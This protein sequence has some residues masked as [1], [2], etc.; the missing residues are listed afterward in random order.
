MKGDGAHPD[1]SQGPADLQSAALTTELCTHACWAR[2]VKTFQGQTFTESLLEE[3]APR[4]LWPAAVPV[5]GA[6]LRSKGRRLGMCS[7]G[8]T[9][10]G[11]RAH[12]D[13]S[14]GP[15]DLQSAVLTTELCTH[16]HNMHVRCCRSEACVAGAKAQMPRPWWR[17]CVAMACGA[18]APVAHVLPA[19][20][21]ACC[22]RQ[23]HTR[24]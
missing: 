11:N 3:P 4:L 22:D 5:C 1:L 7:S 12:P 9:M 23:G 17:H 10:K 13:L 20:Q 6:R 21:Q 14:Q 24:I 19:T 2:Q 15:A 8:I 16:V 18:L